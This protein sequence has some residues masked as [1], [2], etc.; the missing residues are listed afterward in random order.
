[1]SNLVKC[2]F[3]YGPGTVEITELVADLGQFRWSELELNSPQTWSI[4]Q[5]KD[6]LAECLGL[7]PETD[8][9]GVHALWTKS[10]SPVFFYLRP[11]DRTSQLV[12]WLQG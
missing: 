8:T 2:L 1:M 3:Y 9:V 6:W 4:S 12:R 11:I 7:N 10:R 5:L